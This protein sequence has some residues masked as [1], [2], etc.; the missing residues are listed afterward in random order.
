MRLIFL[1]K[2]WT[3]LKK[4]RI[5]KGWVMRESAMRTVFTPLKLN[6]DGKWEIMHEAFDTKEEAEKYI[7]ENG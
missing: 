2:G 4:T 3:N 7:Q 5:V 1:K 6:D